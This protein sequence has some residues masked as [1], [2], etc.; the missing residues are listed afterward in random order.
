[1]DRVFKSGVSNTPMTYPAGLQKGYVG[2]SVNKTKPGPWWFHMITEEFCN[3]VTAGGQTLDGSKTNQLAAVLSN[4]IA[5]NSNNSTSLKTGMLS[6][7]DATWVSNNGGYPK[8]AM[9]RKA[10]GAGFW[11]ST[12]DNNTT[13]PDTGYSANWVDLA[14]IGY[15]ADTGSVNACV[16]APTVAIPFLYNGL[17]LTF[18]VK[19]TNTGATTLK[20]GSLPAYP[21]TQYD[22]RPLN[23]MEL[24]QNRT[25]EVTWYAAGSVW[26]LKS[27]AQSQIS[28][29]GMRNRIINGNFKIDE[30]NLGAAK[31]LGLTEAGL[32][33]VVDRFIALCGSGGIITQRLKNSASYYEQISCTT[34]A[35]S[36]QF[37]QKI[38]SDNCLDLAG[39]PAVLSFDAWSN[40][41]T[42]IGY[43]FTHPSSVDAFSG[44]QTVFAQ[45]TY[46]VS[47]TRT[48]IYIPV[49]V[50][51]AAYTGIQA[52]LVNL[53]TMPAGSNINIA[54]VQL[55]EGSAATKFEYRD[56]AIER[57][58]C[59]HYYYRHNGPFW[60]GGYATAGA[61]LYG[62]IP[63]PTRMR[64]T[65]QV[66][67]TTSSGAN[68]QSTGVSSINAWRA[69]LYVVSVNA[70]MT[71]SNFD[72]TWFEAELP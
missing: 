52:Y 59:A 56:E 32:A 19:N 5:A 3:A 41:L 67:Y 16:I 17:T 29:L 15:A 71:G 12:V 26:I 30:R 62:S 44:S 22:G 39:K 48:R 37:S 68:V 11:I 65:P 46:T 64:A 23:G 9:L 14:D 31:A 6:L 60:V 58:M 53:A 24:L 25:V 20:V 47:P 1:M 45:G 21:I 57:I 4:I 72:N 69:Q 13:N 50:P 33:I 18:L 55:E 7:Y 36:V 28:A 51:A 40:N 66:G 63:F 61:T 70:A 35:S 8:Y 49:N 38:R 42:T 10:G 54:D 2:T 43:A 34:A 27:S